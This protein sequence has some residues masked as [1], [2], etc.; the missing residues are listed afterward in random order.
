MFSNI[1]SFHMFV[2]GH[3]AF[4]FTIWVNTEAYFSAL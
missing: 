1:Y 4:T 2:H 3:L